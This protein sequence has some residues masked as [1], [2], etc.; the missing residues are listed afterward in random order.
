[1]HWDTQSS[2]VRIPENV[3]VALKEEWVR[4]N[5]GDRFSLPEEITAATTFAEGAKRIVAINSYERS[6]NARNACIAHYGTRCVVCGFNF[7]EK[8]GLAGEGL[9]HVHHLIPLAEIG[10]VYMLNPIEDLRPVCPNCHAIIHL[11]GVTRTI[12]EVRRM[13]ERGG[14]SGIV[15]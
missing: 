4:V 2:G 6:S 12:D 3:A 13:I 9:I 15:N 8:Y 7:A 10:E 1:M 5:A 11:G 14:R